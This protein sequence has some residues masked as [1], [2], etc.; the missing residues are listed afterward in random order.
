MVFQEMIC[1]LDILEII[2]RWQKI[3]LHILDSNLA[4]KDSGDGDRDNIDMEKNQEV[5]EKDSDDKDRC[6]YGKG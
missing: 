5:A 1:F 4:E 6:W 2:T 3:I